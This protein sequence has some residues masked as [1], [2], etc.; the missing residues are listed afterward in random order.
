MFI[1]SFVPKRDFD[2]VWEEILQPAVPPGFEAKRTDELRQ[3]GLIDRMYTE[4]LFD[5]DIVLADLTFG[6]SNVYYELGI[7][8]ALSK[9]G[10]VLVACQ[11]TK[12]P[13]DVRNQSVINYDYFAAPS[14]RAFQAALCEAIDKASIQEL[15][16]PV[17]V[18]LPGLVVGRYLNETLPEERITELTNRIHDLE[19]AL[20]DQQSR[21]EEE[22]LLHKLCEATTASRVLRLHQLISSRDIKSVRLLEELAISLRGASYFDE[23]LQTLERALKIDPGDPE[24]LRE[25]GFVYRKKGPPFYSQAETYMERALQIND[26]DS[27]LHGMLGGL[28]RRRGEYERALT[29]YRRAH[30]LEP[31]YLYPLVTVGAMCGVLG[32]LGEAKEWYL[33]LQTTC[34]K[35]ISQERADHWTYLCLG[36]AFVALGNEDAAN[37]AYRNALRRNPPVEDVRSEAEQL[38]FLV[39][40]NFNTESARGVLPVLRE[41]LVA[42]ESR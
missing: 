2:A 8:Q 20:S 28:F 27:E 39:E 37:A 22:R 31:D 4:W 6:N 11:G 32:K 21:D 26:Q 41:Y 10:T 33:K 16:S 29:Q 34:E 18:F 13:F 19:A 36:Q 25:V 40:K 14:L 38:E 24:I 12:L 23:A 5:A 9:K 1:W 30:E 3:P 15:D 42:H 17:H 35:Q 7:R